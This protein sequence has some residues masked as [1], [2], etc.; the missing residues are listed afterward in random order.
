ML[1]CGIIKKAENCESRGAIKVF[2][3]PLEP[4]EAKM[5]QV[6][7]ASD[8]HESMDGGQRGGNPNH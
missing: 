4:R 3:L 1:D 2:D 5:C 6:R 7:L 8:E